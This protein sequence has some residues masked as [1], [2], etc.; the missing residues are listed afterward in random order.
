MYI[1]ICIYIYVYICI[2]IYTYVYIYIHIHIKHIYY[3]SMTY[4]VYS[5]H[6]LLR[7]KTGQGW[8]FVGDHAE[9]LGQ[10]MATK[11]CATL[12]GAKIWAAETVDDAEESQRQR[13]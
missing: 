2:Y 5:H 4:P 12:K 9:A 6:M 1:Y 3:I 8:H 10:Q 13:L 7:L 11:D